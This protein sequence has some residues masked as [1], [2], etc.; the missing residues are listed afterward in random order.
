MTLIFSAP[1][2]RDRVEVVF[3]LDELATFLRKSTKTIR[4]DLLRRPHTLP[5]R[6]RIPGTK[7]VLFRD[8][9][10]WLSQFV[11]KV[12]AKP[13]SADSAGPQPPRRRGAPTKAERIKREKAVGG[14]K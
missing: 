6:V 10:A 14:A 3:T 9:P 13:G 12:P 8:P 4:S 7:K 2:D 11:E 5:P 1:S